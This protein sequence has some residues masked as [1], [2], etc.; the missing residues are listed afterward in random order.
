MKEGLTL[1]LDSAPPTWTS[2]ED[3]RDFSVQPLELLNLPCTKSVYTLLG[4]ELA[5][6]ETQK[7]TEEAQ[8]RTFSGSISMKGYL[9]ENC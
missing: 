1:I 3:R 2:Q 7:N 5:T 9:F 6:T 4:R 8:R